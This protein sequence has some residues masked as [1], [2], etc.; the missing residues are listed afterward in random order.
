MAAQDCITQRVRH[1]SV[2]EARIPRRLHGRRLDGDHDS[3]YLDL[4]VLPVI[5]PKMRF[6]CRVLI[7]CR[8]FR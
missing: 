1:G 4:C 7:A 6:G 3:D 5:S 8:R 2:V